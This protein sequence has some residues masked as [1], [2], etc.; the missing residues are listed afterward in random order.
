MRLAGKLA[1]LTLVVLALILG[2]ETALR[3]RLDAATYRANLAHDQDIIGRVFGSTVRLLYAEGHQEE[4][5]TMVTALDEREP[6]IKVRWVHLDPSAGPDDRAV[7]PLDPAGLPT[8][9]QPVSRIWPGEDGVDRIF[10]YIFLGR[11]AQGIAAMEVSESLAGQRE[12]VVRATLQALLTF[13]LTMVIA[14]GAVLWLERHYVT[15][16]V[17][18]MLAYARGK[19]ESAPVASSDLQA[20]AQALS[21]LVQKA[22]QEQAARHAAEA[23]LRHADRLGT[24][25]ALAAS[26]AHELGS[27]LNVVR[28][29]A[30]EVAS[31][32]F[33][34]DPELI[35]DGRQ[36]VEQCDRMIGLLK[37][38]MEVAR[39]Q[40]SA[41]EEVDLGALVQGTLTLVRTLARKASVTAEYPAP[42]SP[43]LVW[44]V[45]TEL[46]QVVLNLV[47]NAIQAMPTGGTLTVEVTQEGAEV[48]LD[49]S[50]TGV[51]IGPEDHARVFEAFYTTKP[52]GRGTGL[53]LSV[54]A[55]IV[56]EHG[57]RIAL[58]SAPGEGSCFS[59]TLP[60]V[61]PG[62]ALARNVQS[63]GS[64]VS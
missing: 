58:R 41:P 52:E 45:R 20:V 1:L 26:V 5:R 51:G 50:D 7:V 25:G 30:Q 37:R 33:G 31:G 38:L 22:D 24:V 47:T 48:R 63:M 32:A 12:H 3:L 19:L 21:G 60:R 39:S 53:G 49:V 56:R 43:V 61:E 28:I 14:A 42:T 10:T 59:V 9:G 36:I 4:A 16:P 23:Q 55:G 8:A 27:P 57:G 40:V 6:D 11:D 13:A 17:D 2:T 18:Q 46:Q 35:G 15:R 29:H 62:A 64:A 44:G 34:A 54:V